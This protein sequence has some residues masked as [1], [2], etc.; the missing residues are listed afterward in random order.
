VSSSRDRPRSVRWA[1]L[2]ICGMLAVLLS[3]W[4]TT[5][6]GAKEISH[7]TAALGALVFASGACEAIYSGTV[8]VT[9]GT[10]SRAK[11]PLSFWLIVVM[12]FC[13]SIRLLF[14]AIG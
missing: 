9:A 3:I 6:P 7:V 8:G 10:V 11:S 12:F 13:L 4:V 1:V 14:I 5:P 2:N